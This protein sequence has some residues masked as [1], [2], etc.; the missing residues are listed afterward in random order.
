MTMRD[1]NSIRQRVLRP[2][3][4]D[5]VLSAVAI[6]LSHAQFRAVVTRYSDE[7]FESLSTRDD[8]FVQR[9]PHAPVE[10]QLVV[11]PLVA[12]SLEGLP[13][14]RLLVCKQHLRLLAALIEHRLPSL[15]PRLELRRAR[16]GL[17][18]VRT[19][20]DLVSIALSRGGLQR[21]ANVEGFHKYHRTEFSV[22]HEFMPGRGSFLVLTIELRREFE[23]AVSAR[24]LCD[25]NL[26]LDGLRVSSEDRE[27]DWFGL[28]V[29]H[30]GHDLIVMGPEGEEHVDASK[31][32]IDPSTAAFSTHFEQALGAKEFERYEAAEW[33]LQAEQFSGKG[34]LARLQDVAGYF[35][36]AGR[37]HVTSG[38]DI[39]F[40]ELVSAT[41]S[42]RVASNRNPNLPRLAVA[43]ST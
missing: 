27:D 20:D 42:A 26:R 25:R 8:I 11:V 40:G 10:E 43:I 36:R 28:V 18:R 38:L 5:F 35:K 13:E 21:P 7:D 9:M 3:S 37:L 30:S 14:P 41:T 1:D 39:T 15:L 34:Y 2:S 33:A 29:R 4:D 31:Y 24:A 23:I 17:Q 6:Q 12:A 22:R 19:S 32:R 16:F